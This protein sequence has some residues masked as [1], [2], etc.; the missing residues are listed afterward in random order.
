MTRV[1]WISMTRSS[2][3]ASYF[4]AWTPLRTRGP[5]AGWTGSWMTFQ[6]VTA[7]GAR[8][9][10]N[11]IDPRFDS[12]VLPSNRFAGFSRASY[13]FSDNLLP[14]RPL[15]RVLGHG[16]E[17]FVLGERPP[18]GQEDQSAGGRSRRA[19]HAGQGQAGPEEHRS[20]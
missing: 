5:C 18:Q 1:P 3:W 20:G 11:V 19:K 6:T 9:S 8:T 10:D 16:K 13:S 4:S 7:L 12:V 2:S 15:L 17:L 14:R